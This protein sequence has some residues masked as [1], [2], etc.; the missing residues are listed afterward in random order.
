MKYLK[1]YEARGYYP[2][3]GYYVINNLT[4]HNIVLNN[5]VTRIT[6]QHRDFIHYN[7]AKIVKI[8]TPTSSVDNPY[9]VMYDN[10]PDYMTYILDDNRMWFSRDDMFFFS[11]Y[12]E[13]VEKYLESLIIKKDVDLYNL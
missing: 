5:V 13:D 7:I 4:I 9:E 10:P 11:K 6:Q 2:R 1:T 12:K 3:L 8:H